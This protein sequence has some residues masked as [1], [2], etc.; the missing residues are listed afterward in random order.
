MATVTYLIQAN[1]VLA[2]L[3][4]T[5]HVALRRETWLQAR[6]IW[7]LASPF[8]AFL[9]PMVEWQPGTLGHR[10]TFELPTMVVN[11]PTASNPSWTTIDVVLAFH[12]AISILLLL[13][14]A[15]RSIQAVQAFRTSDVEAFSFF[16]LVHV[17]A[18]LSPADELAIRTHEEVHAREWH[19][20][21][22]LLYEIL[23]AV[24]WSNPL[25][26]SALGEVRR[27][28]EFLADRTASSTH[29]SYPELLLAQQLRTGTGSLVHTFSHANLKTRITMLYNTRSPRLARR[30]LLL[31]I[32]ALLLAS[33]L[34]S[35]RVEP[36][37][38]DRTPAV[39]YA[40]PDT[41]AEFPGGTEA[42]VKYL[43]TNIVYP[44]QAREEGIAGT[45]YLS[46]VVKKNGSLADIAV[47]RSVHG[48]IDA[49]AMRVVRAMPAW[50]P[51]RSNGKEVDAQMVLPIAFALN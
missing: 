1:I 17:P 47:K 46:F 34:V 41:Q 21:D 3:L 29:E 4:G 10:S 35:W 40:S 42:L 13:H 22:V 18:H 7:L 6:R 12:I 32:P 48:S 49:E 23:A 30:K 25:W 15:L 51:A 50:K 37:G 31:G 14:L 38:N 11:N 44:T 9:L 43:A 26:R 2:V 36:F 5:Y 33:V 45:V 20:V 19:S 16:K 8:I 27:V 28:H 39:V 24:C